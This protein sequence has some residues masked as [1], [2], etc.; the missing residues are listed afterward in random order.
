[1]T[2]TKKPICAR[3]R[4]D[5]EPITHRLVVEYDDAMHEREPL[6]ADLC[7]RCTRKLEAFLA[8]AN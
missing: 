5:A 2:D 7:P 3:C 8:G 1:M 4:T 6:C